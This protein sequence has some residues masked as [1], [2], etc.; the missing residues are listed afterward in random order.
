MPEKSVYIS[1]GFAEGP[2]TGHLLLQ[3]LLAAGFAVSRNPQQASH[4]IAHSAGCFTIPPDAKAGHIVL[5]DIPYWPQTNIISGIFLKL[6]QDYS[7]RAERDERHVWWLHLFRHGFYA[8]NIARS[9]RLWQARRS[10]FIW[11]LPTQKLTVVRNHDDTFFS[12]EH[13]LPFQTQP[14]ILNMPG[15]HDDCWDNPAPYVQLLQ[16]AARG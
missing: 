2:R 1:Y 8:L 15:Q 12:N 14:N 13:R 11:K 6:I 16:G 7:Y 10:G 5:I 4:I 3:T 9:A